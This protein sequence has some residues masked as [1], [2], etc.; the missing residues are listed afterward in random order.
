M[1]KPDEEWIVMFADV[2]LLEFASVYVYQ[3]RP[4]YVKKSPTCAMLVPL[5]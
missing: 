5:A 4:E 2:T 1:V 3:S